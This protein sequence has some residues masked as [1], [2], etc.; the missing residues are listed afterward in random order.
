MTAAREPTASSARREWSNRDPTIAAATAMSNCLTQIAIR[1][2]DD[3]STGAGDGS[4]V[5]KSHLRVAAMCDVDELHAGLGVLMAE[6]LPADV[7]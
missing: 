7:R 6:P 3:G 4:C 2:G 1:T 5:S